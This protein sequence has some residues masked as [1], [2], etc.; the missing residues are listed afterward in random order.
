MTVTTVEDGADSYN[1]VLTNESQAVACTPDGTLKPGELA[2]AETLIQ[3]YRGNTLLTWNVDWVIDE[4][5]CEGAYFLG[6]QDM[7]SL[8]HFNEGSISGSCDIGVM[9][10]GTVFIYKRFSVYKS[11]DGQ[12]GEK[13]DTGQ[14]IYPAGMYDPATTY[15]SDSNSTP[16]V[17]S[18][19]VFYKLK[20]T[21]PVTGISPVTNPNT[22]EPFNMLK[23]IFTEVFFANFGKLASAVFSGDYMLSQYGKTGSGVAKEGAGDYKV[24]DPNNLGV[25]SDF[26]PNLF[27]NFLTGYIKS[28]KVDISG[29]IKALSG[30]IG[31]FSIVDGDII[32][33]DSSNVE[34][35]RFS[36]NPLPAIS[37]LF[38]GYSLI[39][40]T[41]E[42][43]SYGQF[44]R[45]TSIGIENTTAT[46]YVR[47][48]INLNAASNI[49]VGT[50]GGEL[51]TSELLPVGV[52]VTQTDIIRVYDSQG[53]LITTGDFNYPINVNAIGTITVELSTTFTINNMPDNT[54]CPYT[55][56]MGWRGI[57]IQGTTEKTFIGSD[58]LYSVFGSGEYIYFKR[59]VGLTCKGKSDMPGILAAG[60]VSSLG[61][62]T[63]TWGSKVS[64]LA[65][66]KVSIGIFNVPHYVGKSS[67]TVNITCNVPDCIAY[68][69][70]KSS[71]SMQITIRKGGNNF[72][73]GFDYTIVGE[74]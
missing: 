56:S 21:G 37:S 74:N 4:T 36:S 25:N 29:T 64:A 2:K 42:E 54:N 44:E 40:D 60:S 55:V 39:S 65:A 33:L 34:R 12:A 28:S 50:Y 17:L 73:S 51:M 11:F 43:I 23:Y 22:W 45:D 52:N 41:L 1:V 5:V 46:Y 8:V 53:V 9:I 48:N 63:N 16:V 31:K 59:G 24:F 15:S 66:D 14:L 69:S 68:I 30:N 61:V 35:V 27:I 3:V 19:D 10:R 26:I 72:D 13:G 62:Q 70:G 49:W 6:N 38:T 57:S 20:V 18:G 47:T 7:V 32:G 58:G 71:N 67:Y